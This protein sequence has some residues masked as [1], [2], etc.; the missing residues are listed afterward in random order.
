MTPRIQFKGIREGLLAVLGEGE[1]TDQRAAL[2]GSID[3][4]AGFLRGGKLFVDVGSQALN[5]AE[6]GSL[7][8]E[9]SG[10]GI[11]LW[12]VL[13]SSG[14]TEQTAQ[15]LGLATRLSRQTE[16]VVFRSSVAPTTS[17]EDGDSAIL[18]KRTLRS[19]YSLSNE[20]SI[21]L[22]GD[23]N[24]G[25]EIISCGSIIVWGNL[26]GSAHAGIQGDELAV[27]CAL[28]LSPTTLR[29]GES[30]V[31]QESKKKGSSRQSKGPM[32]ARLDNGE[33]KY[34]EW[35]PVKGKSGGLWP[36]R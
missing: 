36:L 25:A 19:G 34:D 26:R 18:V 4:Q 14:K 2:L 24:P 32:L 6:L 22:L 12:G 3:E 30:V 8:D 23:V 31:H 10:R 28:D 27:V 17:L 35:V 21:V 20:G 7:R 9:I 15:V 13:S 16:K 29:I 5:A 1:W 33:I 11:S